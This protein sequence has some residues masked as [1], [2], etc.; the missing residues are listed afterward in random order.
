MALPN[1]S[2]FKNPKYKNP[3]STKISTVQKS[4]QYKNLHSTKLPKIIVSEKRIYRCGG[5][6]SGTLDLT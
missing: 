5:H 6:Q 1:K 3:H 4:P 2:Q